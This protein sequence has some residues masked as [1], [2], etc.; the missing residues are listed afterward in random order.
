MFNYLIYRVFRHFHRNENKKAISRTVN[1]LVLLEGSLV[2]P[3][4]MFINVLVKHGTHGF[5]GENKLMFF[6][7]IPLAELAILAHSS[8]IK[9]SLSGEKFKHSRN[10]YQK[11]KY[12]LPIGVIFALPILFIFV[13]PVALNGSLSF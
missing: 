12:H 1:F 4:F 7:G 2:V 10:R 13:F 6:I 9:K 5:L 3:L 11:G 8:M